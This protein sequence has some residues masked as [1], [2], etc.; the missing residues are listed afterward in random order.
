MKIFSICGL[1]LAQLLTSTVDAQGGCS[2]IT[3]RRDILSL[4]PQEWERIASVLRR[5]NADGW[6]Q[7]F[8]EI[9][10]NQ[11]G[12]IHGND[13]FFPF[14]RRFLRDFEEVGQRYDPSF[15]IPFW[16]ELR[17]SRSPASS[18]VMSPR[19][20][21]GNGFGSCVRDGLHAGWT[22]GYPSPHCL[23]R[24]YD[25]GNQMQSWYSPE[26][27]YSIMQRNNN[28]HGFREG[29]E[30][31]LHGSV[32]LSIGGD[33]ATTWSSND[34]AFMLHHANLDRLW[35]QWQSW[36]HGMTMDG[37]DRV[38]SPIS[39]N[40]PIPHYGD[41]IGSTMRLGTGRMC[42]RYVGGSNGRRSEASRLSLVANPGGGNSTA[43]E[44]EHNLENLPP[45][46]LKK[47]FPSV[48][49][50]VENM[51][52]TKNGSNSTR[53]A[54]ISN[55]PAGRPMVYPAPLTN[56]WVNMHKFDH[57]SVQAAMKE[58]RE[59]VDDLNKA[60]YKSPF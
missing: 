39:L 24:I 4:S 31:S 44:A 13:N 6:I 27:I 34:F 60:G 40:S 58:A 1:L 15:A 45:N 19:F 48:A 46:L 10:A 37:H 47:W 30:F 32:H 25:R 55:M 35:D 43:N 53:G 23:I 51:D 17:D 42:F 9:H 16:D 11:F 50:Q 20:I 33:M 12:N 21:G 54:V 2:S 56:D 18:P 26:Y 5:M 59:F 29:I 41:P 3:Y 8:S 49:R 57:A 22:L 36:G 7:R 52:H 14:H 28:M 38:G